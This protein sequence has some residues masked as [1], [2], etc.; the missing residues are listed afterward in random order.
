MNDIID[1]LYRTQ[2]IDLANVAKNMSP[3]LDP[4]REAMRYNATCGDE[5]LVQVQINAGK[6]V[7]VV[8]RTKGCIICAASASIMCHT[9]K[10]LSLKRA[11]VMIKNATKIIA[12]GRSQTN[13]NAELN[14]LST[15][16]QFPNRVRCA[17]LAWEALDGALF[18][19]KK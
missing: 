12:D 19:V 10:N 17:I 13:T 4:S 8:A 11:R 15:V 16:S 5:V 7:E 3:I 2:L 14:L 18:K 9:I 1:D 6:L